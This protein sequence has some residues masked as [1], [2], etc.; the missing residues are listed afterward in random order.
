M[1]GGADLWFSRYI[2]GIIFFSLVEGVYPNGDYLSG[3]PSSFS[4][5]DV[6]PPNEGGKN[7]S[8]D[9]QQR[10]YETGQW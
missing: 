1:V 7:Y 10:D 6:R 3:I 4:D 5:Q 8:T 9:G 2:T